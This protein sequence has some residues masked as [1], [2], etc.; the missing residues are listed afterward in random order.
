MLYYQ[1]FAIGNRTYQA[2]R[3]ETGLEKPEELAGF[4]KIYL[5]TMGWGIMDIVSLNV[6][7]GEA[8]IRIH[9][10][11]ECETGKD[12]E[13]PYG[14]FT[15]GILAG[16]FT[17]IFFK[18]LNEYVGNTGGTL[19]VDYDFLDHLDGYASAKDQVLINAVRE[20]V[21]KTLGRELLLVRKLGTSDFNYTGLKW[22]RPQLA[23]GRATRL[24]RTAPWKASRLKNSRRAWK[25]T[26]CF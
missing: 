7:K 24:W 23:W 21:R 3:E 6:E 2:Y 1:G 19:K 17:S 10:S 16:Y 9:Q 18:V 13:T 22:G 11:F 14:H 12:S 20:A 4:L 25:P 15:R 26:G 5:K 8:C